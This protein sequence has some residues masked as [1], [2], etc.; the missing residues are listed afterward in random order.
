MRL[1]NA[2]SAGPSSFDVRC[3]TAL[4]AEG[5]ARARES[6]GA[7]NG[8]HS[9]HCRDT[10]PASAWIRVQ[11]F[12]FK[13]FDVRC[14]TALAAEGGARA[15][16]SGNGLNGSHSVHCRGKGSPASAWIQNSNSNL[17]SL[18][19][20]CTTALAAEGGAR[21]RESGKTLNGTHSVH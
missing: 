5:G 16:E 12:R 20:R 18:D 2:A 11:K 19:V 7:L 9:V 21:A 14:T 4:S 3:T 17:K 13:S 8:S 15:R 6:D 10:I 1:K